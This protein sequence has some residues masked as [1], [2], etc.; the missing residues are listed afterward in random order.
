MD[1]LARLDL[2]G[3]KHTN[4]EVSE[5]PL[6]ILR[7]H[8]GRT[9]NVDEPH[10]H[11]YVEGFDD[12]WAIPAVEAGFTQATD[13]VLAFREFMVHCGVQ[14]MPIIQYPMQ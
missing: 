2:G 9:F 7:K 12:R 3:S 5:P 4:P 6:P 8:N 13:L 11:L 1:R 10:F 14:E